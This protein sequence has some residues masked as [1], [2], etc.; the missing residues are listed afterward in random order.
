MNAV[1]NRP[2]RWGSSELGAGGIWHLLCGFV[3]DPTVFPLR[4]NST[5]AQACFANSVVRFCLSSVV[6]L[7]QVLPATVWHMAPCISIALI[8]LTIFS[9]CFCSTFFFLNGKWYRYSHIPASW[10]NLCFCSPN[11]LYP[12]Q[13]LWMSNVP[14]LTPTVLLTR[15]NHTPVV[16]RVNGQTGSAGRGLIAVRYDTQALAHTQKKRCWPPFTHSHPDVFIQPSGS[17]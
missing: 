10:H 2:Q 5:S 13:S 1:K 12:W 3:Q 14:R 6:W 15:R 8:S 9:P 17:S 16:R 4:E 7:C 11:C